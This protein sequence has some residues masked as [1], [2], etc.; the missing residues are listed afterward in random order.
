LYP[1]SAQPRMLQK[2]HNVQSY[3][4][5][6]PF[7]MN[8]Q[9]IP[10]GIVSTPFVH[11]KFLATLVENK[12]INILSWNFSRP[13]SELESFQYIT[14]L[15]SLN[16]FIALG[17][18]KCASLRKE[19]LKRIKE[20]GI[21]AGHS[22]TAKDY[23][24][25][26]PVEIGDYTDFY[27]SKQ[28]ATNV[29]KLF[30]PQ[31]PLFDNWS[32]IPIGYHGRSSSVVVS[33][34]DVVF[35]SGMITEG[36]ES[37]PS[38]QPSKKLDYELELG[39]I[40][41]KNSD[42]G[43][44]VT[45]DEVDDYLFGMVILNDW[46]ARDVQRY[47]Y[48]PLGPF[49]GKNFATSIS[50]W[51]VL[52]DALESFRTFGEEQSPPVAPHLKSPTQ[53]RDA[54]DIKLQVYIQRNGKDALELVSQTNAKNL[55]WSWKQ[56]IVHHTSNG[57]NLRVGDLFGSGTISGDDENSLGSLLE[58]TK[59]KGPFLEKGDMVVMTGVAEKDGLII[60]LGECRGKLV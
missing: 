5:S 58:L 30:R 24:L 52:I 59:N 51:V 19:I 31:N 36:T 3:Q 47:E 27:A 21:P 20:N 23:I 48:V 25:H 45:M 32:R 26:M 22:F 60:S 18:E 15:N 54:L 56:M 6:C 13:F 12:I 49:M 34:T 29:G 17:R 28:H 1:Q 14:S 40:I 39:L 33:G 41:G 44:P 37:E 11:G 53:D 42:L 4:A 50:G 9:T 35:P 46:S 55:Y 7:P 16:P 10:F 8:D 43:K 2:A 57:C 38:Y